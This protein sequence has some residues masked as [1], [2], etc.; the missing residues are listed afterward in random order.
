MK[1]QFAQS[2]PVA[3]ELQRTQKYLDNA[4]EKII[5]L[6]SEN[7]KLKEEVEHY[8]SKIFSQQLSTSDK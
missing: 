8:K 3:F 4:R 2:S 5:T 7:I 1:E 6:E